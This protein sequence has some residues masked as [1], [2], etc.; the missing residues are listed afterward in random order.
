MLASNGSTT[1]L[2]TYDLP[3]NATAFGD[4]ILFS[5]RASRSGHRH[6]F[7]FRFSCHLNV[8]LYSLL[9][10][11]VGLKQITKKVKIVWRKKP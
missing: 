11:P 3:Q 5:Q 10:R 2:G 4:A 6:N 1:V 7:C 8:G 9:K